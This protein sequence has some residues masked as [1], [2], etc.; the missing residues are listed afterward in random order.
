MLYISPFQYFRGRERKFPELEKGGRLNPDERR[1]GSEDVAVSKSRGIDLCPNRIGPYFGPKHLL[2]NGSGQI[3]ANLYRATAQARF[4]LRKQRSVTRKQRS[5][6]V[7]AR[8]LKLCLR[9]FS[10]I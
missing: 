3:A 9:F 5:V 7:L 1:V 2:N 4:P 10:M 6:R 8:V